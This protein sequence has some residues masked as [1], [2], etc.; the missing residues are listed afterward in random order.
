ML[1][2]STSVLASIVHVAR[3][4]KLR[5]V[6]VFACIVSIGLAWVFLAGF[7]SAADIIWDGS[8]SANWSVGANWT[9]NNAPV[10]GETVRFDQNSTANLNTV[11]DI[12][13]LSVAG[14]VN[15]ALA[16]TPNVG[17]AGPVSITGNPLTIGSTGL[18]MVSGNPRG[19]DPYTVPAQADMTVDV[20]LTLSADQLWK[21]GGP[22]TATAAQA[23]GNQALIVG[24]SANSH[25][26]T[27]N[28]FKPKLTVISNQFDQIIVN[29]K[30]V[31]GSVP[32]Q[33]VIT[34][35]TGTTTSIAY[36]TGNINTTTRVRLSGNN[37]YS[38]GTD[39][40]G[41]RQIIQLNSNSVAG[42]SGPLGTG[43]IT[44]HTDAP[45]AGG[46]PNNQAPYFSPFGADRTLYND[47]IMNN[48]IANTTATPG[49]SYPT[50]YNVGSS[51]DTAH[52]LT[53]N[54]AISI[55]TSGSVLQN[56]AAANQTT[57]AGDMV[58]NGS[59]LLGGADFNSDGKVDAGD[60]VD[61][62]KNSAAHGGA[63]AYRVWRETF[64]TTIPTLDNLPITTGTISTGQT[65]SGTTAP[66]KIVYN[67]NIVQTNAAVYTM[68]VQNGSAAQ[69]TIVQ[70]N[71]QN[72]YAGGTA[73]T[74]IDATSP[75]ANANL[76]FG[77][78]S[79]LSGSTIVSG[80]L[81]TG[82]LTLG[83]ATTGN[84]SS[85][86]ALGGARTI[87]NPI[88][89]PFNQ[90]NLVVRGSNDLTLNGAISG[91]GSVTMNGTGKLILTGTDSYTGGAS[92]ITNVNSGTMLVNGSLTGSSASVAAGATLGGSGS[93]AG[94]VTSTGT[95]APGSGGIGTL[96][97]GNA[98]TLND[99][100]KLAVDLGSA[101]S[102]DLINVA[103]DLTVPNTGGVVTV[104][105]AN[106]G[107][108]GAGTFTLIDYTGT[109]NGDF[110]TLVL[111]TQPGGFTY[112]LINNS[113][114]TS[115]DLQVTPAASGLNGATGVPE[116]GS[117]AL[118]LIAI[119]STMV[120]RRRKS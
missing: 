32:S 13:G 24:A 8:S 9:S 10:G 75:T 16:G 73:L 109:L 101:G 99:T 27:L 56:S 22:G 61:W 4:S 72:T 34:K 65:A 15:T 11:N 55:Q 2:L 52:T 7:A 20:D 53:L 113:G 118:A 117:L 69:P 12:V 18:I 26:V 103:T 84:A 50:M 68:N 63:D 67:G 5:H 85:V 45:L 36:D 77:S 42:V 114:N 70:L 25:T 57:A 28:G 80:P 54:G 38:G 21:A 23:S 33:V 64:G 94:A 119:G 86:E 95:I 58:V 89:L 76:G 71:G 88:A 104:N 90:S 92:G 39:I 93:I 41:G 106:A 98:L 120:Y 43:P 87:D 3:R 6:T 112:S 66:G 44:I 51:G 1:Q 116:P 83:S 102:H 46:L 19:P 96:T 110:S 79:V 59:V 37:T 30:L 29:S 81:G 97:I 31:D 35:A 82:T 14:I 17:V 74:A 49:Q 48:V 62:R 60:Y 91:F 47:I 105:L 100:S 78:S 107:G 40:I 111:G 108:M 115:V